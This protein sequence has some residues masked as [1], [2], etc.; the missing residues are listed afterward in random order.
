M[1]NTNWTKDMSV[2]TLHSNY[3]LL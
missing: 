1:L 3:H 2:Y